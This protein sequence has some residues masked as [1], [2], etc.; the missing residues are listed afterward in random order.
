MSS[1]CSD[2]T[3]VE[4]D[5]DLN[6]SIMWLSHDE[7]STASHRRSVLAIESKSTSLGNQILIDR[8]ILTRLLTISTL[9]DTSKWALCSR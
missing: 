2:A 9:L 8:H 7:K 3:A 1:G 4:R 5:K 6:I